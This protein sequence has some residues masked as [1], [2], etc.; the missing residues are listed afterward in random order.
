[1]MQHN[2]CY[3][4]NL[5]QCFQLLLTDRELAEQLEVSEFWFYFCLAK[6]V[7]AKLLKYEI[8]KRNTHCTALQ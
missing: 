3:H 6:V 4:Q 2:E 1:M 5:S 7:F 8:N